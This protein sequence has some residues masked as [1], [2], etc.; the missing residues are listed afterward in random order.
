LPGWFRTAVLLIS[1]SWVARI[2][3]MSHTAQKLLFLK[4]GSE[5]EISHSQKDKVC[6][7]GE[8]QSGKFKDKVEWRP[9][10]A[11]EAR[12]ALFNGDR[13]PPWG[14]K[15]SSVNVLKATDLYT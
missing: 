2:T 10:G 14:D 5:S 8:P 15:Q 13:V 9:P 3:G 11:G 7:I 6:M 4:K 1:A 12:E